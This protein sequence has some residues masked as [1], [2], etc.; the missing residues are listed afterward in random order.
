MID[1]YLSD[2]A[3]E[4]VREAAS[5]AAWYTKL[6]KVLSQ[7]YSS[8]LLIVILRNKKNFTREGDYSLFLF[9]VSFLAIANIVSPLSSMARFVILCYP[10]LS[11]LWLRLFKAKRNNTWILAMPIFKFLPFFTTFSHYTITTPLELFYASPII[12]VFKYLLL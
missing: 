8:M 1:S 3:L 10:L 5:E 9:T 11:Y 6:L 7:L 4:A 12:L 2:N